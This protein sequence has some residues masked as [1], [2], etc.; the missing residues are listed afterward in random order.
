MRILDVYAGEGGATRGYQLAGWEVAAVDLDANRLRR[1]PATWHHVGDA[2][3]VLAMLATGGTVPFTHRATG[4]VR[5]FTRDDFDAVHT[6]PPCQA[7]TIATAGN[8]A[9]RGKHVRLID[10]TRDLLVL[11][12]VPYVIE[13][14]E[15]ALAHL[16]DPV[17]LCG[18]MFELAARDEDGLPLVLDRHRLFESNVPLSAP[19]HPRHGD[20][21]VAGVYGGS[22]RAKRR[23]GE[24]L[25]EVAPRDRYAARVERG[26]GYVP[27][28]RRVQQ[29]LLGIDWMTIKGM[30]ESIPPVYAEHVGRQL[31]EH[32]RGEAAA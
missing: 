10:A 24:T 23:D 32:V 20:E 12:D 21:Q 26:G 18:R 25:A 16:H 7:Y 17:M 22:R 5:D 4:V 27:R 2:L 14:V 28:S 31:A 1:N 15:Q 9:A 29:E 3:H 19:H 8:P 13:N 6:S 11:L 30:Q